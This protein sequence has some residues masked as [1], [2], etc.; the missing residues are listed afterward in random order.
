MFV[1]A[2]KPLGEVS[3]SW[4]V[5][6]NQPDFLFTAPAF[7]FFLARDRVADVAESFK[8]HQTKDSVANCESGYE[9]LAMFDHSAFEVVCYASVEVARTAG[10]NV[11]AVSVAHFMPK[12][13]SL[14]PIRKKR[15]WVRD[16]NIA[17]RPGQDAAVIA[18]GP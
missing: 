1:P 8:M 15:D 12:S 4:I 17:G 3:P 13:R 6:L 5:A 7:N 14:T 18:A 11:G 9:A 16:D 2:G 10:K